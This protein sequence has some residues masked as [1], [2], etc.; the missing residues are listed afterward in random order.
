MNEADTSS[1][2]SSSGPG[3]PTTRSSS[4]R[5]SS[6]VQSKLTFSLPADQGMMPPPASSTVRPVIKGRGLQSTDSGNKKSEMT[7]DQAKSI[8]RGKSGILPAGAKTESA[9]SSQASGRP[10]LESTSSI[11]SISSPVT[12]VTPVASGQGQQPPVFPSDLTSS[13]TS[14]HSQ[15][16][17]ATASELAIAEEIEHTANMLRHQKT[18]GL[19]HSFSPD[20]LVPHSTSTPTDL[21]ASPLDL[22]ERDQPSP[23]QKRFIQGLGPRTSVA[24]TTFNKAV[25]GADED[26]EDNSKSVRDRIALYQN[27]PSQPTSSAAAPT[28]RRVLPMSPAVL[29]STQCDSPRSQSDTGVSGLGSGSD[30]DTSTRVNSIL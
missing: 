17:A 4:R 19:S 30:T 27:S 22:P 7:L 6:F 28:S 3:G 9:V 23:N 13:S 24:N 21:E 10:S 12:P 2:D 29:P 26:E 16:P 5:T 14:N 11:S 20:R 25:V 18:A 15:P 8:L 1:T